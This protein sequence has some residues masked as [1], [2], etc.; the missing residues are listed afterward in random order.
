[1]SLPVR[2]QERGPAASR[3]MLFIALAVPTVLVFGEDLKR[4][5]GWAFERSA[6][7]VTKRIDWMFAARE[8]LQSGR[9]RAVRGGG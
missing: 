2:V 7:A 5:A 6:A 8:V 3:A 4:I 1:M 9:R